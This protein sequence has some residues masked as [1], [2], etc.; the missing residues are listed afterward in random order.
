MGPPV[1]YTLCMAFW[2]EVMSGFL[3]SLFAG[4]FFV[5]WYAIF[6][7]YLQATDVTVAYNWSWEGI[8][9]HPN[10]DIRNRSKSRTYLLANITYNTQGKYAPVWIDN[11]SLW[12][13][14]LKPGSINH[15]GEVM[16]VKNISS[17]DECLQ[18]QVAVRLQ[19]GRMFWLKGQGP[20][21]PAELVMGRFQ[22]AAFRLR[23]F[24]ERLALTME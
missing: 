17:I 24:I 14:E 1:S 3:G 2:L 19:T 15:F 4:L 9:F 18:L 5:F 20:G 21:Q 13:I 8:K 16:P 7:W 6:Q 22:R 10:F 11:K 23:D 12:G